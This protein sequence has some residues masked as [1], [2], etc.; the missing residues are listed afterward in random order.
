MFSNSS[1]LIPNIVGSVSTVPHFA[2]PQLISISRTYETQNSAGQLLQVL[3]WPRAM[4]V[5][6]RVPGT[7]SMEHS[8]CRQPRQ[9]PWQLSFGS[10]RSAI[11]ATGSA[12]LWDAFP[13]RPVCSASSNAHHGG[14]RDVWP[15]GP[16]PARW[17]VGTAS[18]QT[19]QNEKVAGLKGVH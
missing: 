4:P 12:L 19:G 2:L 7:G 3:I 14:R 8:L 17:P 11:R 5:I 16:V 18:V 6:P 15:L 1:D 9:P 13:P 10:H